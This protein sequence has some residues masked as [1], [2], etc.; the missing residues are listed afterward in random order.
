MTIFKIY[1]IFTLIV[2]VHNIILTYHLRGVVKLH[3]KRPNF[4][5]RAVSDIIFLKELIDKENNQYVRLS[6]IKLFWYCV[7]SFVIFGL[8][9]I[10]LFFMIINFG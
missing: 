1:L 2:L 7:I 6:Y 10:G 5:F 3:G 4:I 9:F 8:I